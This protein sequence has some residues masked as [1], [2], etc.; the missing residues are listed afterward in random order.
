MKKLF[1]VRNLTTYDHY[2]VDDNAEDIINT[3]YEDELKTVT[4][5]IAKS[6]FYA[7]YEIFEIGT[8]KLVHSPIRTTK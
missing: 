2:I 1:F 8:M 5:E 6:W 7:K 4:F 3:I